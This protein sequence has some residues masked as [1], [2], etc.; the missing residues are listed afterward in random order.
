MTG[1]SEKSGAIC[2]VDD[3]LCARQSFGETFACD[4]VDTCIRRGRD[5]VMARFTQGRYDLAADEAGSANDDGLHDSS[6]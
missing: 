4:G 1:S 6:F 3:N 2:E 5:D